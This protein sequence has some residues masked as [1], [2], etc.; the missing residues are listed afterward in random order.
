MT[1]TAEVRS[2]SDRVYAHAKSAILARRYAP[3]D[4]L[5]EG[6]L[7]EAVGVSRTPV[8][9]ALLRLQSEGL[10]RLLPK[11]GALV[12]PVTPAEVQDVLEVRRLIE[13]FAVRKAV[14]GA[15]PEL[16]A[17]LTAHLQAM[18]A[19]MTARNP[20]TYVEADRDFHAELVAATGNEIITDLY[21]SLRDR[22]LRMGVVNLLGEDGAAVDPQRMR[23]MI[24]DHQ[25]ILDAV[26][27]RTVRGAEAAVGAHLDRAEALLTRTRG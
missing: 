16:I 22:Q 18:R 1:D 7:A 19:A 15:R 6:E 13:T 5:T 14:S 11:R 24:A 2:A 17:R 26:T 21:R 4:L 10:V 23:T 27:A 25:A 3:H 8:R 20:A 9:E 12:Q